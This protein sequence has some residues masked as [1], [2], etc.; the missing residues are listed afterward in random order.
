M[1]MAM[2]IKETLS[3]TK[4]MALECIVARIDQNMKVNG[5][6]INSMGKRLKNGHMELNLWETILKGRNMEMEHLNGLI[7][8]HIQGVLLIIILK[9]K[10]SITGQTE[11]NLMGN[12]KIIR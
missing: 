5:K 10:E 7:K 1:Q 8:A 11:E 4:L 6:K 12:G 3:T 9:G 2:C